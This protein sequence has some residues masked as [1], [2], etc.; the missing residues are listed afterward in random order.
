MKVF[1]FTDLF[2]VEHFELNSKSYGLVLSD[3]RMPGM[4]EFEFIRKV[5]QIQPHVKV[6]LMSAFEIS[7]M[8]FSKPL[9]TNIKIDG[10]IQ[11]PISN[12]Q[13]VKT[14]KDTLNTL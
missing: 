3:V 6:L 10:F 9:P 13:L 2:S 5:K 4:P 12:Q 1:A 14:V 8:E 11:K 7:D